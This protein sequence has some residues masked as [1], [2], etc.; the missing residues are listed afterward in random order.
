LKT[1]KKKHGSGTKIF[2][3]LLVISPVFILYLAYVQQPHTSSSSQVSSTTSPLLLVDDFSIVPIRYGC[4]YHTDGLKFVSL[5][6]QLQNDKN[7]TFHYLSAKIMFA[8]YTL[9]NDTVVQVNQQWTDNNPTFGKVHEF[10]LPAN[11]NVPKLGPKIISV[12]FI[13]TAYIQEIPQPIIRTVAEP[14]TFRC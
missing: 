13:I 7:L 14:L 5:H 9:A 6:V 4:G 10:D 12:E 1:K 8:S 11:S 3:A 2:I